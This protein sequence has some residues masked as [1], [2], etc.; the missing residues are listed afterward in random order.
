MQLTEYGDFEGVMIE[1]ASEQ[2]WTFCDAGE[3]VAPETVF[4]EETYGPAILKLAAD[5]LVRRGIEAPLGVS[6]TPSPEAMLGVGAAFDPE[7]NNLL[8]AT[9]RICLAAFVVEHLPR[10]GPDIDLVLLRDVFP[11]PPAPTGVSA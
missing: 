11:A 6:F 4:N 7:Q 8:A 2:G 5:E 1:V 10:S 3:P 9:W